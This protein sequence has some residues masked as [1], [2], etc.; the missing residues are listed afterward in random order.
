MSD[1]IKMTYAVVDKSRKEFIRTYQL[2]PLITTEDVDEQTTNDA[3]YSMAEYEVENTPLVK[4]AVA[5]GYSIMVIWN[6]KNGELIESYK[7]TF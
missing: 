7:Y 5:L 4:N 3:T 2:Y 1:E 6:D